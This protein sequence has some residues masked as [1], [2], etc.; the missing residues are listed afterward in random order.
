[1]A[2]GNGENAIR[3]ERC[4]SLVGMGEKF[5]AIGGAGACAVL[6]GLLIRAGA[7]VGIPAGATVAAGYV[8]AVT[9][10]LS[11]IDVRAHRLPDSVVLP[12]YAFGAAGLIL[13]GPTRGASL[14]ETGAVLVIVLLVLGVMASGGGLGMGDVKLGGMLT[15]A[16]GACGSGAASVV[17]AGGVAFASAG[18]VAALARRRAGGWRDGPNVRPGG[19]IPFGP[20]LLGGFWVAVAAAGVGG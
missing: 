10:P 9:V 12:G 2:I 16:L 14:W 3:G 20:F 13:L 6:L 17:L 18:M 19:H 1:M 7:E 4:P 15:L 8:A 11:V 5:W